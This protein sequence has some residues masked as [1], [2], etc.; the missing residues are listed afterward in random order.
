MVSLKGMNAGTIVATFVGLVV[1]FSV[2][3]ATLPEVLDAGDTLAGTNDS[4]GN[5]VALAG[6]FSS[7]G[8]LP[9]AIMAGLLAAALAAAGIGRSKKR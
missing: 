5:Q 1:A 4:E 9:I 7:S 6:L 2:V 8:V 3:A